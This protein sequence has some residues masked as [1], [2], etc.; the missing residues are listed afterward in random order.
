M[1][2]FFFVHFRNNRPLLRPTALAVKSTDDKNTR[3]KSINHVGI[4]DRYEHRHA[5]LR[6]RGSN[7]VV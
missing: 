6:A 7:G 1:G 4:C 2:M 3:N 5:R